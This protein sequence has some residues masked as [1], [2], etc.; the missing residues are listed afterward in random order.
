MKLWE[1]SGA[2]REKLV[3]TIGAYG[4]RNRLASKDKHYIGAEIIER[5]SSSWGKKHKLYYEICL[6]IRN[7]QLI[8]DRDDEE[9]PY[10]YQNDSWISYDDPRSAS[11]KAN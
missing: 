11:V 3:M 9:G 2:P 7:N 10:G 4:R 6:E 8:V 5:A 1:K